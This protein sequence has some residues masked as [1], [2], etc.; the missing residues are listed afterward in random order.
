MTLTTH[1]AIGAALGSAVGDPLVGFVLGALSHFLVDMIPHGDNQLAD[2]FRIHKKYRKVAVAYVT[3]DA[4]IAMYM[5]MAVFLGRTDGTHTAFAAAVAGSVLPDLL[6]G[7]SDLLPAKALKKFY[8]FHFY[9]H[10]FFSRRYG[11]VKLKYA[12]AGQALVIAILLKH[13]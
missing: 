8:K 13:I 4:I 5:V 6:V 9:F 10:D 2:L 1:A 7:L 11:D 3:V 12:L